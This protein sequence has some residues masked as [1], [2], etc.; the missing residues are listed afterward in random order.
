MLV[1][2]DKKNLYI[3]PEPVDHRIAEKSYVLF[4]CCFL[5]DPIYN[6]LFKLLQGQV[7][8]ERHQPISAGSGATPSGHP[9]A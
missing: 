3:L 2:Q 6:G 5:S 8:Q 1:L 9:D 4:S 7:L